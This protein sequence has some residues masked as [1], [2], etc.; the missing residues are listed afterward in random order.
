M[1]LHPTRPAAWLGTTIAALGTLM[2]GA[3]RVSALDPVRAVTQYGHRSWADRTGLPGQA[4]YDIAQTPD[5]Y[6]WVRTGNRLARFDGARFT[7]LDLHIGTASIGETAKALSRGSDGHLLIR[8]M[9]RTLRYQG[10]F[11]S[12]EL[13]PAPAPAGIARALHETS[14]RRIWVGSDC[15][16]FVADHGELRS[17]AQNTGLVYTFLEDG[18]GN[19]FI[20]A[21][22]GLFQFRGDNLLKGPG[23]FAPIKDVHALARDRNGTLWVGTS[24]GLYRLDDGAT[25]EAVRASGVAWQSVNAIT[26]DRDGN[27]W[28]G[29]AGAG[30]FRIQ[31]RLARPLTMAD[32]L[33]SNVI[34]S[35][36]ED[37]EGSLWIGTSGGLDQLRDTAL[38]TITTKEGLPH[39]NPYSVIAARDGSVYASTPR[40]VARFND[41]TISVF[42]TKEGLISNYCMAL[43][44]SSDGSIW[45]G[46]GSGLSRLKDGRV[47]PYVGREGTKG[48]CIMAIGE[49]S[50]GV[51]VTTSSSQRFHIPLAVPGDAEPDFVQPQQSGPY[52]FTMCR[53][54]DG[55]L[56]YGTSEGLYRTPEDSTTGM[57]K[58]D[59]ITFP[60]TSIFDDGDGHLWLAGRTHGI[61]RYRIDDG[62]IVRYTTADGLFDDEIARALTDE[63]GNLWASTPNGIFCVRAQDLNDFA[64]GARHNIRSIAYGTADG[65]RTTECSIPEQQPAGGVA[66]D[67]KLWFATRQGVVVVDPKRLDSNERPPP[68]VIERV[69]V[70]GEPVLVGQDIRLPPGKSRLTL[71]YTGLS[72][73]APERI[74]FRYRLLG[75]DTDWVDAGAGRTAEYTRLPPGSYRFQVIAC[76]E[77][78]IWNE[79]GASV[80]VTLEPFLY[81]TRWFYSVCAVSALLVVFV[82]YRL[83][84]R[85]LG[86]RQRE[87]ARCVAD[88][89]RALQDEIADHART[90]QALRKAKDAAEEAV[91]VKSSFLAN[92][93]HEI[94]TPM[95][96]VLGMAELLLDTELDDEQRDYVRMM[97]GAAD[98]LLRVINDILDFSKVEAGRVELEA[99][100]FVLRDTLGSVMGTLDVAAQAKDLHLSLF[101]DPDVPDT[102][103]GDPV[104][105]GQVLTNLVGN[106]IKFTERG[107]VD[108]RV[109]VADKE[110]GPVFLCFEVRDTGIGIP[111]DKQAMIFEAFTQADSST[112]RRYGGTGLGLAI[113]SQLVTLMGGRLWVESTPRQGSAFF[114]TVKLGV[115]APVEA[116]HDS[117][118]ADTPTSGMRTLRIL[119]AEDNVV[120]QHLAVRL[121]TK[122]GHDVT[123]C[124]N[125]REAVDAVAN[126]TFDVVLMDV[127]MPVLDGLAATREI[128]QREQ[129]TGRHVP[130]IALT[131]HAMKSDRELC[132]AAGMDAFVSKPIRPDELTVVLANIAGGEESATSELATA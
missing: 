79:H 41:G 95:N 39:D 100:T 67:G 47:C 91:R 90:E 29:T 80:G 30:L 42:T 46:T 108:V 120:N 130:I 13:K 72:L 126:Q 56:W 69:L 113:A 32:G 44:E 116:R 105:L 60:V 19:L 66:R 127:Q 109:R 15:E 52:V 43:F 24:G 7:P 129:D 63:N 17:M 5:G 38:L 12:D 88:R 23:D 131:A 45:V 99:C 51:V 8:T 96:G 119:L 68:V 27:V 3:D 40:G 106:A 16:L 37:R 50:G 94:R 48:A 62:S 128:R 83:R 73:R 124:G 86:A 98:T 11:L 104:R 25:P 1:K 112:T 110:T 77:D 21:S 111:A 93:S 20:G 22:V 107:G 78:G 101:C 6:L 75:L 58:E 26:A 64:A 36:F 85:A 115:A 117:A 59:R 103:V 9:T 92:M 76:N 10:G 31:G 82:A 57:V 35:L 125:G 74:R 2:A 65:M 97:R 61:T 70:N 132:L 53:G 14:E 71:H 89:T 87:L 118:L 121:L 122:W 18:R 123:V 81:Q 55:I 4:V 33:S 28:V 102:I 84:V 49:D 54:T 114:F 34:L